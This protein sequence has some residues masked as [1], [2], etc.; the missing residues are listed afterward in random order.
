[1]N[2]LICFIVLFSVST[3]SLAQSKIYKGKLVDSETGF[4][5]SGATIFY[6]QQFTISD[7]E[8]KFEIT[9]DG[10]ESIKVVINHIGYEPYE[11][12]ISKEELSAL[13]IN[14]KSSV[15]LLE[16]VLISS[17]SRPFM[18]QKRID[19][20]SIMRDNPKNVGDI[21][22]NKSGFGVVKRGGGQS[23]AAG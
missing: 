5:I 3:F 17:D 1:M 10:N 16:E 15:K 2:K 19:Q 14:L 6:Q 18:V 21:F 8:G 11:S 23:A 7:H 4:A 20:K 9:E 12:Q 22:G 13:V